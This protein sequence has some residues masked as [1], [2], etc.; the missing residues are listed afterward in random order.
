MS[1]EDERVPEA[2]RRRPFRRRSWIA[3]SRTSTGLICAT[4]THAYYRVGNHHDAEDLTEQAFLQAYRHFERARRVE[5]AA[6]PV[7]DPDRAQPGLE[8]PPRS[9]PQADR[10]HRGG[11]AVLASH[12]TERVVE[13]ARSS[14]R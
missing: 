1:E 2:A 11:R 13:G 10:E 14:A 5:R 3:R 4:S 6:A 8:L 12:A 7:A 9:R